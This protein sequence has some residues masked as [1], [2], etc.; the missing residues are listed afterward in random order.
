MKHKHCV[1]QCQITQI[2]CSLRSGHLAALRVATQNKREK[3]PPASINHQVTN[4]INRRL[5]T[6]KKSS[7]NQAENKTRSLQ[8]CLH[9][10]HS[11]HRLWSLIYAKAH[12]TLLGGLTIPPLNFTGLHLLSDQHLKL[13]YC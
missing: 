10:W 6:F 4:S 1:T 5:H 7:L 3:I 9:S 11:S 13:L 8:S 2:R 12:K